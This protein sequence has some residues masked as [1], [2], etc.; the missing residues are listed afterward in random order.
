[1]TV[2]MASC[3]SLAE[4]GQYLH[5]LGSLYDALNTTCTS[6]GILTPWLP[7]WGASRRVKIVQEVSKIAREFV[8]ERSQ[9]EVLGE[10]TIDI[11]R[12]GM[13]V[14]GIVN[15]SSYTRKNR[16]PIYPHSLLCA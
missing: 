8:V 15:V 4:N 11:L 14:T 6:L 12:D 13:D 5:Q 1:M 7:V 2:R 10:D 16:W 3:R 9:S